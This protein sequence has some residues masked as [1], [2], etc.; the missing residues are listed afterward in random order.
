MQPESLHGKIGFNQRL[1]HAGW[2]TAKA[3]RRNLRSAAELE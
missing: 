2:M 1:T 3:G